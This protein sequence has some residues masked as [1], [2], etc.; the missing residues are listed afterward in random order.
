LKHQGK[1]ALGLNR[2]FVQRSIYDTFCKA[3]VAA[4][5]ALTIGVGMDGVI[6]D[7]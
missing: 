4:T 7:R 6:S 1:T 3:F 2:I 5:K